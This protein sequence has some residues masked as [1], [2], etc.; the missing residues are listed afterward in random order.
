MVLIPKPVTFAEVS[1]VPP[2]VS[3]QLDHSLVYAMMSHMLMFDGVWSPSDSLYASNR[4]VA[5]LSGR[6][7]HPVIRMRIHEQGAAGEGNFFMQ[8]KCWNSQASYIL[9]AYLHITCF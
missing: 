7:L 9:T 3:P 5:R 4:E 2:N 6:V 8:V 1:H